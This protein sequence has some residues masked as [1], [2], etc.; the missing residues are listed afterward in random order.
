MKAILTGGLLIWMALVA[1]VAFPTQIPGGSL[2]LPV[3]CSLSLW[4]RN[5][6]GILLCGSG[7][8]VD[9]IVRPAPFPWVGIVVPLIAAM[10]CQS[11]GNQSTYRSK[12]R[13]RLIPSALELPLLVLASICLDLT[14]RIPAESW[15]F[16]AEF[17]FSTARCLLP[18]LMIAMPLSA[19]CSLLIR[20]ADEFGL[21]RRHSHMSVR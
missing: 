11:R 19:L 2:V 8:I 12:P 6:T 4:F 1:E 10:L 15:S 20:V 13:W 16:N 21:R 17:G 7:L 14:I 3:V 9:A 18:S 5:A